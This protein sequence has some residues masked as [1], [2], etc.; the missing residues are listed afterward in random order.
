GQPISA[1]STQ[2]LA[3]LQDD[4]PPRSN[5]PAMEQFTGMLEGGI[6]AI[7]GETTG[8]RLVGDG[9]A[10]ALMV[11]VAA[12]PGD[13]R[14]LQGQRVIITGYITTRTYVERGEVTVLVAQRIDPAG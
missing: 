8:W 12:V 11:D 13:A 6:M 7:G 3:D 5:P 10:G 2:P 9:E 1:P 4:Q 14:R